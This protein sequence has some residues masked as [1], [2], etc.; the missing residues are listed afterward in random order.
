MLHAAAMLFGLFV[1][2]FAIAPASTS[3]VDIAIAA[4]AALLCTLVMMRMRGVGEA[5]V[6]APRALLAAARRAPDVVGGAL[7]TIRAALAADVTLQPALVRIKTRGGGVERAAFAHLL[8]ATPGMAVV[9]TDADGFL[10][11]V[12][13][14]DDID[15]AELGR[16]ERMVGAQGESGRG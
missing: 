3:L 5:F 6:R 12:T 2:W 4:A 9:E 13:H 10:V 16:L 8:S 14:E 1:I 11:H 7:S 15:A